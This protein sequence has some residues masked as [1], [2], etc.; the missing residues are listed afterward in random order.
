MI[1][2]FWKEYANASSLSHEEL[3]NAV[4]LHQEPIEKW[5]KY[6]IDIKDKFDLN[7]LGGC[8]GTTPEHL[9]R[10]VLSIKWRRIQ[11]C[12]NFSSSY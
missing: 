1:L 11:Y 2:T 9:K 4:E 7:I 10:L 12:R 6:Q 8:C 5:V 3:D